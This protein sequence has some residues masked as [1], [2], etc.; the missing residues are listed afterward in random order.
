MQELPRIEFERAIIGTPENCKRAWISIFVYSDEDEY[1]T[2]SIWQDGAWWCMQEE[3]ND[4]VFASTWGNSSHIMQELQMYGH[5]AG[6]D[7]ID[8]N[9]GNLN[10]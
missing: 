2:V 5:V 10:A 4:K 3:F 1:R 6:L 7:H 9:P 8:F